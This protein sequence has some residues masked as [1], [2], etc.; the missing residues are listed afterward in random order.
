MSSSSL[1]EKVAGD[2]GESNSNSLHTS[3]EKEDTENEKK[4]STKII[5]QNGADAEQDE[6]GLDISYFQDESTDCALCLEPLQG[7]EVIE[8]TTCGHRWHLDCIKEQLAHAQPNP[9]QRLVLTGCRCAK[10]GAVCDHPSLRHLTRKTDS[11]LQKVDA[12][13][14]EQFD[15]HGEQELEEARR[16][17]AIYMCSNCHEPYFGGTI[18]CA[19][20]ADGEVPPEERLCV[21]CAPNRILTRV[22]CRHPLEHRG[23]HVWKC[24][25]CCNV[26]THVCYG[27]VHF[28]QTC[29]ERNSQRVAALSRQQRR[30]QRHQVS[31]NG[32]QH[33]PPACLT[34]IPCSG[35]DACPFPRPTRDQKHHQ[36]GPS[37]N[38]EQVYYCGWCQSNPEQQ[39]AFVEPPGSRNLIRNGSGQEGLILRRNASLSGVWQQL[40]PHAQW[41]VEDSDVPLNQNVATNFVSNFQWCIMA[42]AVPLYRHVRNASMVRIEVSAKYMGRTDCPSVF[43][44]EAVLLDAQGRPVARQATDRLSAP[45]DFWE[46]ASLLFEPPNIPNT[47]HQIVMIVHGKDERFWRGNFGSKVTDCKVRILGE[48]EELER[49]ML[50]E[51]NG[52]R[53]EAAGE[54]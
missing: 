14:C 17:Y 44:L 3:E 46:R 15:L 28:C 25:Y 43:L 51:E 52:E 39:H 13:L 35:G 16:K 8:L 26:A 6:D 4:I 7:Q 20:T 54:T 34:A 22:Q 31:N 48:P 37:A 45:A 21:A 11:L 24:R 47:A 50:P 32:K 49:V 30:R 27:T 19:D 29:H 10:C 33:K 41:Q 1:R 23:H 2:H 53:R 12:V 40:N 42:Q 5:I 18:A 9:A 36:N 38:C